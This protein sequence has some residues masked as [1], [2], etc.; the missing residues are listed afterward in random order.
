MKRL[1]TSGA[2]PALEAAFLKEIHI[3]QLASGTCGRACRMLGCCK[4]DKD[5]CIVMTLY[6]KSA[7]KLLEDN[8]GLDVASCDLCVPSPA[9]CFLMW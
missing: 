8:S 2:S 9:Y 5:P 4:L 7:A 1:S 3:L 6:P